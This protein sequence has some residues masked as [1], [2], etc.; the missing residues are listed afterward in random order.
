[1]TTKAKPAKKL[2]SGE[3]KTGIKKTRQSTRMESAPSPMR[4]LNEDAWKLARFCALIWPQGS[5]N[6][7]DSDWAGLGPLHDEHPARKRIYDALSLL[8]HCK[9][10]LENHAGLLEIKKRAGLYDSQVSIMP[11]TQDRLKVAITREYQSTGSRQYQKIEND[12]KFK[13]LGRTNGKP[14]LVKV[15]DL[16]EYVLPGKP[17]QEKRNKL[18]ADMIEVRREWFEGIQPIKGKLHYNEALH[19]AADF[20]E[21][22]EKARAALAADNRR[23]GAKKARSAKRKKYK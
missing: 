15:K 11:D 18:W 1:M 17:W 7:F 9:Q 21:Y 6:M 4:E 14:S 13:L 2:L 20:M 8:F 23:K 3:G 19:L 5:E 10:V 12:P 16:V 22:S